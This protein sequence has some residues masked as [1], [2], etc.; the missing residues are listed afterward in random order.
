[1]FSHTP[2]AIR[3]TSAAIQFLGSPV[4]ENRPSTS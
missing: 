2:S 1:V 4:P 3:T